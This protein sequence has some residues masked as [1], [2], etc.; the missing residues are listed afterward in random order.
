MHLAL[1]ISL[2][3]EE[4]QPASTA[5]SGSSISSAALPLLCVQEEALRLAN[6]VTRLTLVNTD[7]MAAHLRV[8]EF[9][10]SPAWRSLTK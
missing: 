7:G 10:D 5:L 2:Q 3:D 6:N 8:E 9:A 4:A 1:R